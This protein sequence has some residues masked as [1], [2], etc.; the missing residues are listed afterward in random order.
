M[1]QRY[2]KHTGSVIKL[3]NSLTLHFKKFIHTKTV[4][5]RKFNNIA[6]LNSAWKT[7]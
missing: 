2:L 4:G 7:A 3:L 1:P 6:Y 5:D